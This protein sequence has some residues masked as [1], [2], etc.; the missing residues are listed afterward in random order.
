MKATIF[1][2]TFYIKD[3]REEEAQIQNSNLANYNAIKRYLEYGDAESEQNMTWSEIKEM[4]ASGLVDF[5]AHSHKHM[6]A[7]KNLK[8]EG[9]F[10]R[11]NNK[12]ATNLYC[13]KKNVKIGYPIL[14]KRGE[15][16]IKAVTIEEDFFEEF[17]KFYDNNL[18]N[19]NKKEILRQGQKFIDENLIKLVKVESDKDAASRIKNELSINKSIIENKLKKNV[20]FFCWPWGHK[21]IFAIKILEKEGIVGFVK[22]VKGTNSFDI[23]LKKIRRIELRKFTTKK[24]KINLFVGRNLFLGRIYELFS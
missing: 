21:S 3:R 24:F 4:H 22:T 8:L 12:D 23:N 7:F 11:E 1:L 16:S 17:K 6:A 13:Y 2:N 15:Y 5:Q 9:V 20:E 10:E 14:K 19:K 18:K